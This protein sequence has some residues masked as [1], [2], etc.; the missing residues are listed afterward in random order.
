MAKRPTKS[1]QKEYD[2][3]VSYGCVLCKKLYGIY[4][5]PCIHHLTG[6]G[7]SLKSK[8]FI[9][10]CHAHHQGKEGIHHLG[11]FTWEEKYGTQESL[12]KYYKENS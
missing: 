7:M 3:C 9:P 10:L 12:L 4:S 2:K 6:A 5:P 11:T 1:I 8:D